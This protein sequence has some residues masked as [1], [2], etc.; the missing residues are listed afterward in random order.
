MKPVQWI[1]VP[2]PTGRLMRL[3]KWA[4]GNPVQTL[5][6]LAAAG[7]AFLLGL[8]MLIGALLW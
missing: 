2:P 8:G 7:T 5:A 4:E 3:L 1:G 6:W